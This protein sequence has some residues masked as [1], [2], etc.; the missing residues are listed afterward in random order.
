MHLY[1]CYMDTLIYWTLLCHTDICY[2]GHL[3]HQ[4]LLSLL[5]RLVCIHALNDLVSLLHGSLFL[6]FG[7]L[8]FEYSCILVTLYTCLC[9]R[10]TD[11][12]NLVNLLHVINIINK[13][14][15]LYSGIPVISTVTPASGGNMCGTKCHTEKSATLHLYVVGATSRIRTPPGV[16]WRGCLRCSCYWYCYWSDSVFLSSCISLYARS[17]WRPVE[18]VWN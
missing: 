1:H 3:L 10:I 15:Y 9:Y 12:K 14:A 7:L 8:L 18:D 16:G 17:C 5:L 11:E 4:I 6:L 13:L 2:S